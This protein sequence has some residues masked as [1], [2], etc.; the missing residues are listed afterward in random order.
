[1][2]SF[3]AAIT[4]LSF[5][6]LAASSQAA[7]YTP[8]IDFRDAGL[9]SGADHQTDFA[10][11]QAGIDLIVTA[12]PGPG[13][14]WW[15]D[16]DGLGIRLSYENDE[17]E[18]NEILRVSFH[19]EVDLSAI[20]IS[21]LFVEN[22][23]TETGAY[24]I[25]GGNWVSF[26]AQTL[27]GSGSNGEHVILFGTPVLVVQL[28]EFSAPGKTNG[29]NHEFALMGFAATANPIPEPGAAM[30]FGAGLLV[31]SARRRDRR[32]SASARSKSRRAS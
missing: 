28:V 11:N 4:V 27:P 13:T 23:Y 1:M 17:I 22:G 24:R 32:V 10:G 2:K 29:A 18:A 20:Y 7:S 12:T 19:Q 31:V 8:Q 15:D 6:V 16:K 26:D 9:W 25:N 5:C 30:L 21:D 14:L 3:H